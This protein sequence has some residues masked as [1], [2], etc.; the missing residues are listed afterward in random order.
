MAFTAI[1][2]R[3]PGH[4]CDHVINRR[5]ITWSRRRKCRWVESRKSG[6]SPGSFVPFLPA[7]ALALAVGGASGAGR[8]RGLPGRAGGRGG[9]RGRRARRQGRRAPGEAAA[10]PLPGGLHE[11]V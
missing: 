4:L 1:L 11:P 6:N 5:L 9:G 8:R 7:L 10:E 2:E 3:P